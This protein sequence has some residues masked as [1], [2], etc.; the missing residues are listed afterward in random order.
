GRAGPCY[1]SPP[2]PTSDDVP[3]LIAAGHSNCSPAAPQ[4]GCTEAL[5]LAHG[6]TVEQLVELLRA[7]LA[8]ATPQ[9]I[10]AGQSRFGVARLRI[11]DAGPSTNIIDPTAYALD[12]RVL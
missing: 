6:F 2:W 12:I 11:T 5:M 8:T 1:P 7:G 4:E 3:S 10:V 9:R